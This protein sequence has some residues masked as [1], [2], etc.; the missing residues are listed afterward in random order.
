MSRSLIFFSILILNITS[1]QSQSIFNPNIIPLGDKEALMGNTGTGGLGSTGAVFYNPAALTMLDGN[2]FSLSASAY[3]QYKFTSD[4]FEIINDQK[5][6]YEAVDYQSIPSSVVMA[7]KKGDWN[8]ALSLLIPQ[9]FLYEGQTTW[10]VNLGGANAKFKVLQNFKENIFLAGLSA[11]RKLNN[12]FSVGITMYGSAYAYTDITDVSATFSNDP[13]LLSV[14][15][16]RTRVH[17]FDIYFIAGV[18]KE[19]D[20]WNIGLTITSPNINIWRAGSYYEYSF[21]NLD[22]NNASS[23]VDEQELDGQ[24]KYPLE[25]RL[26]S[27]YKATERTKVALD[28]TYRAEADYNVFKDFRPEDFGVDTRGQFRLNA[29]LEFQISNK[30]AYYLGGSYNPSTLEESDLEAS[31]LFIGGHTGLKLITKYLE[32]SVGFFYNKGSGDAPL[33]LGDGTSNQ[34]YEITGLF[35]GSNYKF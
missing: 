2:S 12:G 8:I 17:P 22:G 30:F 29:G 18:L 6:I 25:I 20:K 13:T 28:V 3:M 31:Q 15:T 33:D 16:T 23:N 7:R 34:S 32:T 4:P 26:G 21:S 10:N 9:D 5:L 35:L 14:N 24:F 11:A 27:V 19:M 1:I